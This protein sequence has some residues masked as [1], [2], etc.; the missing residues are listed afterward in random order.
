LHPRQCRVS[1]VAIGALSGSFQT[2]AEYPHALHIYLD[3]VLKVPPHYE[4][5]VPEI[6]RYVLFSKRKSRACGVKE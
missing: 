1:T 5:I 3:V 4:L 6:S 2:S